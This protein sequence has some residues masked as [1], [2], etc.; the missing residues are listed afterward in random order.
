M[1]VPKIL[2][3]GPFTPTAGREMA[4]A[5]TALLKKTVG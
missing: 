2:D 5:A 3:V 1:V 4:A